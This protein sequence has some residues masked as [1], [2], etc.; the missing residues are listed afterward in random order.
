MQTIWQLSAGDEKLI[1]ALK[2]KILW[3][4]ADSIPYLVPTQF[5]ESIFPPK[6]QPKLLARVMWRKINSR[7]W[8]GTTYGI[9]SAMFYKMFMVEAE[10]AFHPWQTAA[11]L[12]AYWKCVL[13]H[14]QHRTTTV[15]FWNLQILHMESVPPKINST[16]ELLA[17]KE[18]IPWV[19]AWGP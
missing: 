3:D 17:H 8:E 6:T 16:M 4:M 18:S 11:T 14:T 5:Q 2:I 13:P 9:E 10:I 19:D 12:F 1:P 15:Q 7:N